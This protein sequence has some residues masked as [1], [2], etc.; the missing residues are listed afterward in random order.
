MLPLLSIVLPPS[1]HIGAS[2]L[3]EPALTGARALVNEA[4]QATRLT[5]SHMLITQVSYTAPLIPTAA[6]TLRASE[7]QAISIREEKATVDEQSFRYV[8]TQVRS[9]LCELS[10]Y[11][12]LSAFLPN[13]LDISNSG[14]TRFNI[15]TDVQCHR[16]GSENRYFKC[17]AQRL[18]RAT[19]IPLLG[20]VTLG[21]DNTTSGKII[22]EHALEVQ[23]EVTVQDYTGSRAGCF[24]VEIGLDFPCRVSIE[25]LAVY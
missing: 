7:S 16:Y 4:G 3:N 11:E 23:F 9:D 6:S 10:A 25:T 2:L 18:A 17:E 24:A 13:R 14:E 1:I 15:D 20:Q 12:Q 8:S 5:N 21:V 19:E 22:S